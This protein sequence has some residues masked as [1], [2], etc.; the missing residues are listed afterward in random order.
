MHTIETFVHGSLCITPLKNTMSIRVNISRNT[1]YKVCQ[2]LATGQWFSPGPPVSSTNKISWTYLPRTLTF[3]HYVNCHSEYQPCYCLFIYKVWIF[4]S[5]DEN[6]NKRGGGLW[7]LM[8]LRHIILD[9]A[10]KLFPVY[11]YL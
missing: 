7:Y 11:L 4:Q 2:W 1:H 9:L 6:S 10:Y 3:Y 5:F 8:P